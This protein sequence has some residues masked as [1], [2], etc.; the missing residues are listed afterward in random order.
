MRFR[1]RVA[2]RAAVVVAVAAAVV[3]ATT[4]LPALLAP[5]PAPADESVDPW[6]GTDLSVDR[7]ERAG[8]PAPDGDVGTVVIDRAHGNRFDREDVSALTDAVVRA[9]G[10]VEYTGFTPNLEE[11]LANASVFVVIDPNSGFE[12]SEIGHLA[13]FLD[14]GGRLLVFAEPNRRSIQ[15]RGG[16]VLLSTQRTKLTRLGSA[17]GVSFGTGYLYDMAANDG[18]FKNVVT[19]PAADADSAVVEGVD[20][21]ALYTAAPVTVARGEV[22][23]RTA[24]SAEVGGR[25]SPDGYPVAAL[26]HDGRVLAVGDKSFLHPDTVGVA[27]NDVFLERIVEFMASADR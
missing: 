17:F 20:R 6:N 7:L 18:G 12:Q 13:D 22:L 11:T 23:L 1:S 3:V 25:T 16:A 8:V 24:P 21:V 2:L 15:Q 27:D 9:G 26:T 5:A 10:T 4:V 19:E 14:D